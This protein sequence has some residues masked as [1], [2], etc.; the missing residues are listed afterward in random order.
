MRWIGANWQAYLV[1]IANHHQLKGTHEYTVRPLRLSEKEIRQSKVKCR[2]SAHFNEKNANS[3]R[4]SIINCS[5][6]SPT[7]RRRI[8]H[9]PCWAFGQRVALLKVNFFVYLGM[10]EI[11]IYGCVRMQVCACSVGSPYNAC[12]TVATA[13]SFILRSSFSFSSSVAPHSRF[14]FHST[15]KGVCV[16]PIW[17]DVRAGTCVL[18]NLLLGY[19]SHS[20]WHTTVILS[21]DL[22]HLR[23]CGIPSR[24]MGSLGSERWSIHLFNKNGFN[25]QRLIK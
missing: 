24:T 22:N 6:L 17:T 3:M 19:T 8:H 20:A 4:N 2:R 12:Q 18:Y 25:N 7:H 21:F 14:I 1:I 16:C 15:Q 13:Q 10:C 23:S 11:M 9:T 5:S